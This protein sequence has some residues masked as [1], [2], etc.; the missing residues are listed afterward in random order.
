MVD[1]EADAVVGE[2]PVARGR[3][4]AHQSDAA[5]IEKQAMSLAHVPW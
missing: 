1:D 4:D 3:L 2:F 5:A